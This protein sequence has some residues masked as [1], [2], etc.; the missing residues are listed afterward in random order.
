MIY[1][2]SNRI[3]MFSQIPHGGIGAELGVAK[4]YN[5]I[6]LLHQAKPN[7]LF[8]VD[9]WLRKQL[10]VSYLGGPQPS[11]VAER[12]ERKKIDNY[13]EFVSSVFSGND[14]VEICRG[15]ISDWLDAQPDNSLD[16]VYIDSAHDQ[17]SMTDQVRRCF[18]V[19][20]DGGIIAGHDFCVTPN[21]WGGGVVIPI[22]EAIQ[23]GHLEMVG[24]TN[25]QFPSFMCKLKK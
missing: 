3:D 19:V 22:I 21:I 9:L 7:K 6:N 14:K 13:S 2:H 24:V 23:A 16:W 5:A 12:M 18:R 17:Q 4:G 11:N 15:E 25:E 1:L 20:K 8:L 10:P